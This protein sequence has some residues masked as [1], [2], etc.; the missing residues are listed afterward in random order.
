MQIE[1]N[2]IKQNT[3]ETA[4][5][6]GNRMDRLARNLYD[7]MTEGDNRPTSFKQAIHETIQKQALI[8][9]ETG[10]RE[11]I[12]VLVRSQCYVTLQEAINGANT[13]EKLNRIID[14]EI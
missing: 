4:Q 6:F 2:F 5:E 12:K 10:L 7:S 14:L 8:N 3:N 9:F 1:F 11:N 13:E